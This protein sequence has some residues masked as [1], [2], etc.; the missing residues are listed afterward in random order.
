[1]SKP[2]NF[3][4]KTNRLKDFD[5][6]SP[7]AY[8]IT[9][10]TYNGIEIFNDHEVVLEIINQLKGTAKKLN[11]RIFAYCIMPDH[12]HLLVGET[13]G[14]VNL[15]KFIQCFKQDTGYN[16]KKKYGTNLWQKSYYDHILR[17]EESVVEKVRYI[18][19]NPVRKGMVSEFKEYPFLGS[20]VYDIDEL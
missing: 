16:F 11:C 9:I 14:D 5:Y 1:M 10:C 15:I 6:R 4:R 12:V 8:F 20:M 7:Y 13:E 19:N 18:L 17:K 2:T 3:I